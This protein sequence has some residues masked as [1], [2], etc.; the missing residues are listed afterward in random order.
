MRRFFVDPPSAQEGDL[1]L[2]GCFADVLREQNFSKEEVEAIIKAKD[3][4]RQQ[5]KLVLQTLAMVGER[6]GPAI[7]DFPFTV[8]TDYEYDTQFGVFAKKAKRLNT[9]HHFDD[10]LNSENFAKVTTRLTPGKTY[11]VRMFLILSRVSSEDCLTFLKQQG[12][13][14]VGVQGLALLW[15]NKANNFPVG[16]RVVSLD[17][18]DT[19]WKD[20]N[21]HHRTPHVLC[22]SDGDAEFGLGFFE[23][24]LKED[25]CLLC[26]SEL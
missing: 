23:N 6:F 4:L 10:N 26:V 14:F 13:L 18:K 21:S 7:L 22:F 12:A 11:R 8:L 16:R 9:I 17:E 5:I 3:M 25:Q 1:E 24:D 15:D 2:V 19:L 20:F